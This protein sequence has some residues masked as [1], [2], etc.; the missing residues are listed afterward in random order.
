MRPGD[1]PPPVG[2]VNAFHAAS[3]LE[4][5]WLTATGASSIWYLYALA[6]YLTLGKWTH[7]YPVAIIVGCLVGH[8]L[9]ANNVIELTWGAA[10][11]LRNAIYFM[12]GCWGG[13]RWV[14]PCAQMRPATFTLLGFGYVGG[15]FLRSRDVP[16]LGLAGLGLSILSIALLIRLCAF[17]QQKGKWRGLR[18]L[19][20]NTLPIY[21]IHRPLVEVIAIVLV[22]TLAGLS[23]THGE[24]SAEM[25]L[26]GLAV[27]GTLMVLM[28]SLALWRGT[29]NGIG[30]HLYQIPSG[31]NPSGEAKPVEA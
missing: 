31:S 16:D 12:L 29:A 30:R 22:P 5:L 17:A 24:H 15:W 6:L 3:A 2:A 20:R 27:I 1:L 14:E 25:G 26:A 19:G 21:V 13:A 9:V 11:V 18:W 4:F 23:V 28:A 7:R 8:L 10:S